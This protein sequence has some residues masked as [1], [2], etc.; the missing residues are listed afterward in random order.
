[1]Q[2]GVFYVIMNIMINITKPYKDDM[3]I[4][5]SVSLL[6]DELNI[7]VY[8]ELLPL[9][10]K[11]TERFEGRYFSDEALNF[12][13]E[14]IDIEG[15]VRYDD[16]LEYYI[17]FE[18][19]D[20]VRSD[21]ETVDI[22]K[23]EYTYDET[24]FE[25]DV[26]KEEGQPA[27]LI[28]KEGRIAAISAANYFIEDD[29]EE[30]ELA[31]ETLPDAEGGR[32]LITRLSAQAAREVEDLLAQGLAFEGGDDVPDLP[33]FTFYDLP[34]VATV[35]EA[36]EPD[37]AGAIVVACGGTSDIPVA[38]EAAITAEMLG[39]EVVRLYDV[40][41]AGLHRLLSHERELSSAR[42]VVAVAGMEGALPSVIGGLV[43]CPVIAV[44][45]S[46]GYG[47]SLDGL[48]ALLA[49][50]NSCASGVS[51]VNIDNGFGAAFQASCINH[52]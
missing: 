23:A 18:G 22:E 17:V 35:G 16:A 13:N 48:A 26:I 8:E 44:P 4:P 34:R 37:G 33:V 40:G 12:L 29:D 49:M 38:E 32:V 21:T 6:N 14:N 27:S 42:V 39:N 20:A 19:S 41:V 47:A 30:V 36:P 15:Y 43:S 7:D 3:I 51:V 52:L 46:V 9:A 1:M 2:R 5:I 24:E 31:V 50:L 28:I 11:Y 45:T 10:R 25:A